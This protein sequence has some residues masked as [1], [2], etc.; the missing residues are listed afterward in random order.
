MTPIAEQIAKE[1]DV[2]TSQVNTAIELLDEG[3]TVPFIARYRKEATQ[4]LD[5]NHLRHLAQRLTYLRDLTARRKVIIA[6]IEQQG[7]LTPSLANELNNADNKTRLEDLYLPFKP[8]RKTKGQIAITAGLEPL[9]NKIYNNWQTVPEQEAQAFINKEH[10]FD[11]EKSVLDGAHF[12][13]VER[14]AED[15]NLIQKLRRHLLKQAHLCSKLV[16]G[17]S[18][19]AGKY[20]DYFE[21]SELLRN[22]PSH[23]MLAMLRGR[24]E[25][26]LSL[27]IDVDPGQD[28]AFS[29]AQ[30]LI[31]E[32]FNLRLTGQAAASF[33]TKVVNSTWKVKLS[34]SLETELLGTLA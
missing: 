2:K 14:F 31:T 9:A 4:G 18:A 8:K 6:N 11:D 20:R 28:G 23:R 32:H 17:K 19:E 21:H 7:K 10:G 12:I 16:K 29:S 22:V 3:A 13:L 27:S 34:Q 26:L 25:G 24:N 1:L 33:L 5:D 15:A 30:Q